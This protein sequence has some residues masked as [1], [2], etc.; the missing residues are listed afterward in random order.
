[1]TV[2]ILEKIKIGTK[3]YP[4]KSSPLETYFK[5]LGRKPEIQTKLSI[6]HRGYCGTWELR[7]EHLY[8][9]G[10]NPLSSDNFKMDKLFPGYENRVFAHWVS[11][12][13]PFEIGSEIGRS[14][15]GDYPMLEYEVTLNF[16]NGK[17]ID[18]S[19]WDN[20]K[21]ENVSIESPLH[22]FLEKFDAE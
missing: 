22:S 11:G 15:G 19:I 12:K 13:E 18:Y 10:I 3:C 8:L 16:S 1:M 6:C 17:V 7:N 14:F 21:T 20:Q 5:L 2:Q 4:F 9:I